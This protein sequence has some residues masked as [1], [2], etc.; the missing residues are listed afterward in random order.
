MQRA[1]GSADARF[2]MIVGL[3]WFCRTRAIGRHRNGGSFPLPRG[4][5]VGKG[6]ALT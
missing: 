1:D 5:K 3:L 6:G 4:G 2:W